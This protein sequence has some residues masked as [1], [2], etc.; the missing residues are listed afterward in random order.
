MCKTTCPREESFLA[1]EMLDKQKPCKQEYWD[2]LKDMNLKKKKL[3]RFVCKLNLKFNFTV[4]YGPC[5]IHQHKRHAYICKFPFYHLRYDVLLLIRESNSQ[6]KCLRSILN[7]HNYKEDYDKT[8][9]HS[10]R[11]THSFSLNTN[12]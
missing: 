12:R 1:T 10:W 7:K 9:K 3:P 11:I 8:W 2:E 4:M 6:F 5:E